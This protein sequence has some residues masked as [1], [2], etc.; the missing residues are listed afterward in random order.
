MNTP[1]PK[2]LLPWIVAH[3]GAMD[4]APE[5]TRSA[6]DAAIAYP[7]DGIELDVQMTRDGV[8]VVFHDQELTRINGMTEGVA[9]FRYDELSRLDWGVWYSAS[10]RGEPVLTLD[11]TLLLYA[12]RTRLMIEIKSFDVDR[13]CGRPLEVT[14]RVL[15]LLQRL[16]KPRDSENIFILSFDEAV[17]V[18]A[19]RIDPR[20]N[21]VLNVENPRSLVTESQTSTDQLFAYCAS[22]GSLDSEIVTHMHSRTKKVMTYSCNTSSDVQKALDLG[23][24]VIMTD[25]PG[26]VFD[27]LK[28]RHLLQ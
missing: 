17:L 11:D 20:W 22:I 16:M 27:Y 4:E 5:N 18:Y 3:R 28:S 14:R 21:I 2:R 7:I 19:N 26:W 13:R 23:C 25:K 10:F 24:D 8:L 12:N 9:H 15:E 1:P 6:F